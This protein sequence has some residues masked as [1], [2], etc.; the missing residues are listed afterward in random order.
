MATGSHHIRL[1]TLFARAFADD[2]P[3]RTARQLF[4]M[5]ECTPQDVDVA[6]F[7]DFFTSMVLIGLEHYGFCARGEGGPFAAGGGLAWPDGRLVCNTNGGQLSEAFIHGCNN[8]IEA[9]RQIRGTSTAQVA[10][11][12]LAFVAGGN[13]DPTGAVILE[14]A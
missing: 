11:C 3:A 8:T 2:A 12:R 13:S 1:S 5:A 7:Y 14:R 9:V 10:D 4:A 6:F